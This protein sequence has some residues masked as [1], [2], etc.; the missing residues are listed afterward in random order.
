MKARKIVLGLAGAVCFGI[1]MSF[2]ASAQ[3]ATTKVMLAAAAGAV[4][5][6]MI[7]FAKR[8]R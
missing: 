8:T 1:L 3:D 7:A 2:R 6:C 5:G 4:L